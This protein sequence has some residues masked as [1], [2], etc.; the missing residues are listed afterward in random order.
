MSMFLITLMGYIYRKITDINVGSIFFICIRDGV[1]FG[2]A[3]LCRRNIF[4]EQ[5]AERAPRRVPRGNERNRGVK[6]Y[7]NLR[8][9]TELSHVLVFI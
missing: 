3:R 4:L 7:R 2:E 8:I 5:E 9:C 1:H 6:K